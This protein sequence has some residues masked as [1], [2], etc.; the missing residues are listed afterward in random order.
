M[1]RLKYLAMAALVAFAA[2]DEGEEVT[3]VPPPVTGTISGSVTI[4]GEA[5]S[6]VT[7]TLSNGETAT[8]SSSGTYSFSSVQAGSYTVTIPQQAGATFQFRS[9]SALI[10]TAGQNV[11]V[12]FT[13][14][15]IETASV[16]VSVAGSDGPLGGVSVTLSGP[17]N[18]TRATGTD[19]TAVFTGLRAGSYSVSIAGF[20]GSQY[21][22][23]VTTQS[24]TLG[25][26]DTG[27]LTFA[28]QRRATG[29]I[30]GA[31][32]ID[33][34]GYQGATI[35]LRWGS[36]SETATSGADGRFAFGTLLP[37][38]YTV[39]VS[40]T[41]PEIVFSS[42]TAQTV[43]IA[44]SGDVQTVDFTGDLVGTGSIGGNV[45]TAG[46]PVAGVTVS[47]SG[48]RT[49]AADRATDANGEYAA[50]TGLLSGTYTVTISGFDPVQNA[51]MAT[52]Q[53]VVVGVGQAVGATF[54]GTIPS[55]STIT[56]T[57]TVDGA[58]Y[59]NATVTL[60]PQGA[61]TG[62][63]AM[64]D[65]N[66][67][68]TYPNIP[69]GNHT[70]TVT[71]PAADIVFNDGL[72][73]PANVT[74]AAQTVTVNFAGET[75]LESTISGTVTS[76]EGPLAGVTVT[77][78]GGM[79][80][81]TR[82]ATT[83]TS[84][85]YNVDGLRAGDYTVEISGFDA[86]RYDFSG[87]ATSKMVTVGI[88]ASSAVAFQGEVFKTATISGRFF[89]DVD[90]GLDDD[91]DEP[92]ITDQGLTVVIVGGDV[93]TADS[94]VTT[95]GTFSFSGLA[96]GNY[97]VTVRTTGLAATYSAPANPTVEV[98][99]LAVGGSA[100]A[101]FPFNIA[102]QTI[103]VQAALGAD[104]TATAGTT[105]VAG[106]TVALYDTQTNVQAAVTGAGCGV[107]ATGL[108]GA[109]DAT[110]ANG[111]VSFTFA[112]TADV[113]PQGGTDNIV[114]ACLVAGPAATATETYVANG[115]NV[116]EINYAAASSTFTGLDEFDFLNTTVVF[117]GLVQEIDND[118]LS[119]WGVVVF[120]DTGAGAA[121]T[122]FAGDPVAVTAANGTFS[123]TDASTTI[124]VGTT[125][126]YWLR[127]NRS[128]SAASSGHAFTT[129]PTASAAA[130]TEDNDGTGNPEFIEVTFDGTQ[131]GSVNV[132]SLDVRYSDISLYSGAYREVDDV[133][134]F[135]AT[136]DDFVDA[137]F[138]VREVRDEDDAVAFT[139]TGS[140]VN[141][142]FPAIN[143]LPTGAVDTTYSIRSR[144]TGGAS[145]FVLNDTIQSLTV[146]GADSVVVLDA[147]GAT[148][149][150]ATFAYK[151]NNATVN[152]T[153]LAASDAT[154]A[155]GLI[156]TLTPAANNIQGSSMMVDT[157]T[158]GG[159]YGFT[160]LV[161]GPYNV[162]IQDDAGTW[163]HQVT[164]A[165]NNSPNDG[166]ANPDGNS[167][168][169][170][171][172]TPRFMN[173]SIAGTVV[174]D[175]DLDMSTL[176]PGEALANATVSL[177]EDANED[178][179]IDDAGEDVAVATT[180]TNSDG[181]YSFTGLPEGDYF[182]T[183][184]STDALVLT[185]VTGTGTVNQ[186]TPAPIE[187][188][189]GTA[190]LGTTTSFPAWDY[191]ESELD[192]G[193]AAGT[194]FTF[195]FSNT[196]IQ[197]TF[198]DGGGDPVANMTVT[199]RR[200]VDSNTGGPPT[201]PPTVGTCNAGSYDITY[202]TGGQSNP[203]T[204]ASGQITLSNLREG[205]YEVT[206]NPVTAGFTTSAPTSALFLMVGSADIESL[207]F[208]IS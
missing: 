74:A 69:V 146:D 20:D 64:T 77:V 44:Q 97:N 82:T 136:D 148:T 186:T 61:T 187:T 4:S 19:G 118:A 198:E 102:Q 207:T 93:A 39:E 16:S 127:L 67:V 89:I 65:A 38:N 116:L 121:D 110:D 9:A 139:G 91:S 166:D 35:T 79:P 164:V 83:N 72:T 68:Y 45:L 52:S 185:E 133:A 8:T 42:S 71:S 49:M 150:S 22:F 107:A 177:F 131:L 176:D 80:A 51:F 7:V 101:S 18:D 143:A 37:G 203:I 167:T 161:E 34:T 160:G 202:A 23:G 40:V 112:R 96:P 129:T 190:S 92:T 206:P 125:Q 100:P 130:S 103:T 60:T 30:I 138:I 108:I 62:I 200:C 120:E 147:V 15:F 76:D 26:G 194:D 173:T 159:A 1:K 158:A 2:C 189:A 29:Q 36:N 128:A 163:E 14:E 192:N 53:Q 119:G 183:A 124:G 21:D 41:D 106:A 171:N 155:S 6:G 114:F 172:F 197:A 12:D 182:I 205:V 94:V 170:V 154:A 5:Q 178:G 193:Q 153:A 152:G 17:E 56:G 99:G 165:G 57:V 151:A 169:A 134:G 115:E 179:D 95:D 13:G 50:F 31:V 3:V 135:D 63:D 90:S 81:V 196:Q 113:S 201:S 48:G 46:Q 157:T 140:A 24:I 141:G 105:P 191:D 109:T 66:G 73:K 195:L 55:S 75:R 122:I 149:T 142:Q 123:V 208:V 181:A 137:N 25:V 88:A 174:N 54:R 144:A 188:L 27:A 111:E 10:Q 175:R 78:T 87:D 168:V 58:P 84:G 86:T 180:T 104:G 70:V 156:V 117:D 43:T 47:L 145:L 126:S 33:N 98:R 162:T 59:A 199:V 28:G 32:T 11:Q 85:A 204:D 132:G 184:T